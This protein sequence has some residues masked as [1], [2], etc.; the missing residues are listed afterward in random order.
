[1]GNRAII[2]PI[3]SNIGVYLHW[4]GGIGSVTGFLKYCEMRGFRSFGGDRADGYGIARFCQ[5]VGNFFGGTLSLGICETGDN[6]KDAKGIDNGIYVVDG[7]AVVKNI[8]HPGKDGYDLTDMLLSID[9]KQP[10]AEQLGEAY[11][12]A[13]EVPITDVKVGDKVFWFEGYTEGSK[14]E[15]YTVTSIAPQNTFCNGDVSGLPHIDKYEDGNPNNYL[16]G[17]NGK[18]RRVKLPT[19]L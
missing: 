10:E 2:K 18:L 11:I 13:E 16:R 4:N 14:P 9:K 5:V 17:H 6:K 15:L 3:D 8:G 7:W 12:T 1:M 19:S